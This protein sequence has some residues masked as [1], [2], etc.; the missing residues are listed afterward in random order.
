MRKR[1]LIIALL[2]S[3]IALTVFATNVFSLYAS[4]SSTNFANWLV[5]NNGG[6]Y[7]ISKGVLTLS[8]SGGYIDLYEPLTASGSFKVIFGVCSTQLA[9]FALKLDESLPFFGSTQGINFEMTADEG[10]SK[11]FQISRWTEIDWTWGTFAQPTL[12]QWYSIQITVIQAP[13]EV[14]YTIFKDGQ[15]YAEA[16]ASDM[17]NIGFANLH[18]I[19]LEV[20]NIGTYQVRNLT[21]QPYWS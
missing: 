15:L 17:T 1:Y 12:N 10:Q 11:G 16:R 18:Y 21:I 14:I 4:P 6:S 8:S 5:I 20:W 9:G 3:A 19:V 13:F 2:L 7:S